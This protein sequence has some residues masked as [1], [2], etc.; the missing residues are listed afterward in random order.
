MLV[1]TTGQTLAVRYQFWNSG[2][3]ILFLVS[4]QFVTLWIINYTVYAN[5]PIKIKAA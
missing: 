1:C 2:Y 3:K 4:L 5:M